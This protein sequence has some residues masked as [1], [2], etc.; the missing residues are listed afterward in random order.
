MPPDDGVERPNVLFVMADDHAANAIGAYGSRL[1]PV[2][3]T[4]NIDRLAREGARLDN[5]VCTNSICTPSR[6]SILTGQ[7]SH[8]NGVL[9]LAD[10]ISPDRRHLAHRLQDAGYRTGIVGKWHLGT[11]PQGF[12]YYNV[13]PGQGRYDDP[14]LMEHGESWEGDGQVYEGYSA[15]VIADRAL[16]WLRG[17]VGDGSGHGDDPFFLQCHFKA[18]HRAWLYPRRHADLFEDTRIPEPPSLFED[19]SH[20]SEA[21]RERGSTVSARND[22][23]P[24]VEEVAAGDLGR[25]GPVDMGGMDADERTRVAYQRYLAD[26]LR[27]VA[28]VDDN[29]GRLLGYLEEAGLADETLVIYTSDQGMFLGEHDH[30]DKRWIYEEALRMPF[31]ARYPGAIAADTFL[32]DLVANVDFAPTI[33]D[34]AGVDVPDSMDGQ[35]VRATLAGDPSADTREAVYYRYWMHLAHHDVPAHYGLRTERYALAFF[36]G[37]P[38]DASGAVGEPSVPGWELYDLERDPSE[39]NNVYD[40]P[41]Y[42]D[43]REELKRRLAERK[44][45]LG[46]T[47]DRHPELASLRE[48]HW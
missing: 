40:D 47:D 27:T 45:E 48:E 12:D 24:M 31:I 8:H 43:V 11:E 25:E 22:V 42:A 13:L 9:T 10:D 4:E 18:P 20:R 38:L 46:D 26:Y 3:P 17:D 33:L 29:V 32:D 2:T 28:A 41:D 5:C 39:L 34:Y 14:V 19:K 6:A 16:A 15:D 30:Y 37:R 35:S 21:T 36:Y 23:Q 1:G 44:A 7:H